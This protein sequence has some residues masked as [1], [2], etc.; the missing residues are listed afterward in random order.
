MGR[1]GWGGLQL[2]MGGRRW[3]ERVRVGKWWD[4]E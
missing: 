1:V 3:G 4:G 2:G